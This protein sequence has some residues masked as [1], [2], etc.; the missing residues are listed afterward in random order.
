[1][2]DLLAML[3][4]GSCEGVKV[5]VGRLQNLMSSSCVEHL[6]FMEAVDA[7]SYEEPVPFRELTN[8]TVGYQSLTDI[9]TGTKY[10]ETEAP[11]LEI[12]ADCITSTR[13]KTSVAVAV[14]RARSIR[15]FPV[16]DE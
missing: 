6:D 11:T 12:Q 16:S 15:V 10:T 5:R 14:S 13:L 3:K 9:P 4:T 2:V 1:M 7:G 8:K